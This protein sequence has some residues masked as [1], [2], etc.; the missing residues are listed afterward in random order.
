MRNLF[1]LCS[2]SLI[3]VACR[4]SPTAPSHASAGCGD[5]SDPDRVTRFTVSSGLSNEMIIEPAPRGDHVTNLES[6]TDKDGILRY[7]IAFSFGLAARDTS[8]TFTM[9][10]PDWKSVRYD[11]QGIGADKPG[12]GASLRLNWQDRASHKSLSQTFYSVSGGSTLNVVGTL[13][14]DDSTAVFG[15]FCGTMRDS[16]GQEI[17]IQDGLIHYRSPG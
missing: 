9:V 8:V 3:V 17:K 13:G 15:T 2:L 4:T 5:G 14:R 6:K 1:I 7:R 16:L 10:L 12:V 11:W